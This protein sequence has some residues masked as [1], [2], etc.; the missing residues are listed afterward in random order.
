MASTQKNTAADT[1]STASRLSADEVRKI[2]GRISDDPLAA[3]LATGATAAQVTEAF[4]WLTSDEYLAGSLQRPLSG[5]V[6]EV[7]DIL[8][9]NWPA[10]KEEFPPSS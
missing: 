5:P 9:P 2:V 3:I 7:Y 4:T 6:A 8:R 10:A 1:R